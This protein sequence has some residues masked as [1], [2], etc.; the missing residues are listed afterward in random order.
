MDEGKQENDYILTQM[1]HKPQLL[2]FNLFNMD[3][4]WKNADLK[5]VLVLFCNYAI[6]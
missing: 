1:I 5:E 4:N 2:A 3:N 6:H